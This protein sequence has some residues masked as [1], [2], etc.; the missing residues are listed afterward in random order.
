[1]GIL[2]PLQIMQKEH[3]WMQKLLWVFLKMLTTWSMTLSSSLVLPHGHKPIAH[4]GFASHTTQVTIQ[5]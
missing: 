1:M 5:V 3:L 4:P 2:A